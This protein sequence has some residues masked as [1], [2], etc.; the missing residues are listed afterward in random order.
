MDVKIQ[1][2]G[3][4]VAYRSIGALDRITVS[5]EEG[6]V[7]SLVGP[8]G[9]GK[10]TLLRCINRILSPQLG[11][12]L[13]DGKDINKL[14]SRGLARIFGYV[15][16]H[17]VTHLPSTVLEVVVMGR[18]PYVSWSLGRRDLE[19][20]WNS[21]KV[22]GAEHLAHRYFGEISGGE[23]QKVIIAR[24][25]AQEPE[26]LLLDEPTSNLDLKH[27]LEI[28]NLIRQLAKERGLT[29]VMAL[30][31]LN[32][33]CQF[34]DYVIILKEGKVFV[35]GNPHQVFTLKNIRSVY[36]VDVAILENPWVIVPL[37]VSA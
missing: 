26:V 36:G 11:T 23:R 3:V 25:L 30:H 22:A 4:S 19:I 8:N 13:L 27:Q 17:H 1:I 32:L 18:R 33:A 20:A 14:D 2:K 15:P 16:Q 31:D 34:S 29:V 7:T 37:R 9:A 12:V 28:L 24:A 5:L 21:L 35:T 10:S 6:S